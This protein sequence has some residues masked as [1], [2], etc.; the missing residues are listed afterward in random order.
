M[1]GEQRECKQNKRKALLHH[2][3]I[4]GE[5]GNVLEQSTDQYRRHLG[6]ASDELSVFYLYY[7]WRGANNLAMVVFSVTAVPS[8][9]S[10]AKPETKK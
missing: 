8:R 4:C 9:T 5:Q 6:E 10:H 1:K 7:D 2:L 3:R